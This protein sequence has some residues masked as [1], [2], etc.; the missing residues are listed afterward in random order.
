MPTK[1]AQQTQQHMELDIHIM[2]DALI[3]IPVMTRS[4]LARYVG[5]TPMRVKRLL[6]YYP[7]EFNQHTYDGR[8]HQATRYGQRM[9]GTQ[10]LVRLSPYGYTRLSHVLDRPRPIRPHSIGRVLVTGE[11]LLAFKRLELIGTTWNIRVPREHHVSVHAWMQYHEDDHPSIGVYILPHQGAVWT[12][13]K[14]ILRGTVDRT[15]QNVQVGHLLFLCPV[16][17]YEHALRQLVQMEYGAGNLH[18]LPWESFLQSPAF[19][20]D[21]IR[22]PRNAVEQY[23]AAYP[24]KRRLPVPASHNWFGAFIEDQAGV[25][26]LIDCWNGGDVRR[27]QA[28][29]EDFRERVY[30]IPD[31]PGKAAGGW[32]YAADETMR[33]ALSQLF[34][35][36]ARSYAVNPLMSRLHDQVLLCVQIRPSRIVSYVN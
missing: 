19:F 27:V 30:L 14:S 32:V 8:L 20:L 26:K 4:Q 7:A 1:R 18:L 34:E 36:C 2:A 12:G 16:V 33:D 3:R 10:Y 6:E 13:K 28:W 31:D 9:N 35:R 15:I 17:H 11:V 22:D 23:L 24:P 29:V 21:A 5:I 25:Y